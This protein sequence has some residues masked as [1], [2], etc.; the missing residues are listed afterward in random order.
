MNRKRD[1]KLA[2]PLSLAISVIAILFLYSYGIQNEQQKLAGNAAFPIEIHQRWLEI[3]ND[4]SLDSITKIKSTIDAYFRVMLESWLRGTLL[5]FGFLFDQSDTGAFEDYIYERGLFHLYLTG[6][7]YWSGPLSHYD[8]KP[9]YDQIKLN[10]MSASVLMRPKTTTVSGEIPDRVHTEL[11]NSHNFSLNLKGN[12]WLIQDIATDDEFRSSYPRGTNFDELAATFADRMRTYEI[13]D[14]KEDEERQRKDPRY[15]K[16][17]EDRIKIQREYFAKQRQEEQDRIM[18]YHGIAG[19]YI[20]EGMGMVLF[21][22]QDRYLVA[23]EEGQAEGV[24]LQRVE[25]NPL[26]FQFRP[27]IG[28]VIELEF[29][30]DETGKVTKCYLRKNGEEYQGQRVTYN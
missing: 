3:Q 22:V 30:R 25:H 4:A 1:D 24:I 20:F 8:Y 6:Q 21:F 27:R 26:E 16:N 23:K 10:A 2:V 19:E 18:I 28:E 12:L 9:V 17:I 15:K 7:M 13:E 5:D 11:W 14:K 29:L